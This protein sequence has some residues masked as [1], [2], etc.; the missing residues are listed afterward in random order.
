MDT[1]SGICDAVLLFVI[2][3]NSDTIEQHADNYDEAKKQAAS[4]SRSTTSKEIYDKFGW[5][6]TY[7]EELSEKYD[8]VISGF[9]KYYICINY[10]IDGSS[11]KY[12][13]EVFICDKSSGTLEK[14]L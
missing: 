6:N 5:Q 11:D 10:R 12:V 8:S 4:I 1:V 2:N 14:I 7:I 3:G 13:D 9:G